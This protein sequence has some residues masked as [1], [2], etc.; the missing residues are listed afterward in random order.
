VEWVT[1]FQ[2]AQLD[3]LCQPEFVGA[4]GGTRRGWDE[5]LALPDG[6]G[7]NR[8][9]RLD[10]LTYLPGDLLVKVDRMSMA[11]SLEVR[12]PFLDHHLQEF[13]I[14]LPASL[15]L[16]D[17]VAKW[18]LRQ[19]AL[20][21]GIPAQVVNRPKMGFAI[22]IGRWM[23]EP[24]K[25]WVLDLVLSEQARARGYF[26]AAELDRLVSDHLEGSAD[27]EG[28]LWNLAML[29]LWHRAC[30]DR[31]PEDPH[32]PGGAQSASVGQAV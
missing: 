26:V 4:A 27:H 20:P 1:H 7:V 17:G 21:R 31:P 13:A 11:H 22:P 6:D 2:P 16:R 19:L 9:A 32:M 5:V 28:R 10:T 8:Y 3:R 15:K 29:E 18:I 30:L 14:D 24:L 12:S 23:R 25:E